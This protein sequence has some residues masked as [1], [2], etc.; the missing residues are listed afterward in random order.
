MSHH[1]DQHGHHTKAD[2]EAEL[3][4]HDDW[5]RHTPG[6]HHQAAHGETNPWAVGGTLIL[7]VVVTFGVAFYVLNYFQRAVAH[8]KLVKREQRTDLTWGAETAATKANWNNELN[9]YKVLDPK[10]GTVGLP[11]DVAMDKVVAEYQGKA[12]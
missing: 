4:H 9:S 1:N 2:F 12:K 10:T 7:V 11:L 5:F 6:E 8:E 3:T